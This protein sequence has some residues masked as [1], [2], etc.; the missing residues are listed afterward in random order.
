VSEKGRITVNEIIVIEVDADPTTL[1]G[2]DAPTG[3]LAMK[4]GGGVWQKTGSGATEWTQVGYGVGGGSGVTPPFFFTRAGSL[5]PGS[6]LQV[7]SVVSS[8]TGQLIPG[9]NKITKITV[10]LSGN[11]TNTE[12]VFQVQRRTGVAT[13]TDIPGAEITIPVGSYSATAIL[14]IDLNHDEEISVYYK[15]GAANSAAANAVVGIFVVPR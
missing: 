8:N 1:G 7:G 13:F 12:V 3:S 5:N 4:D 14:S 6:Y 2:A 11:V 15:T 10:S 9:T